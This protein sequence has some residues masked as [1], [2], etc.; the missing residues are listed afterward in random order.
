M[1]KVR[2]WIFESIKNSVYYNPAIQEYP[3]NTSFKFLF[4]CLFLLYFK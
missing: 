2:N 3:Y 1:Q 4:N